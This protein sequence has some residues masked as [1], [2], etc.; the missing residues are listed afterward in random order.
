MTAGALANANAFEF[1]G[2][3]GMHWALHCLC[4]R[5]RF[6][7]MNCQDLQPISVRIFARTSASSAAVIFPL[8]LARLFRQ[9][10][11]LT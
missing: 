7:E 4:A 8:C 10:R 1:L 3:T 5:W 11:L 9:S 2:V 6:R